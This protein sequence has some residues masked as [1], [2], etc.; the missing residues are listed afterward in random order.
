MGHVVVVLGL[1]LLVGAVRDL[2]KLV[3]LHLKR[4]NRLS[5]SDAYILYRATQVPS[6]LWIAAFTVVVA[7]S[8]LVAWQP[9]H[10]QPCPGA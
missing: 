8:W 7:A 6:G 4:R 3:H 9:S 10:G 1:A 2:M 5:T